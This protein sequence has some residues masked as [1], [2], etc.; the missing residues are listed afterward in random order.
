MVRLFAMTCGWIEADYHGFLEHEPGRLRVPVPCYLIDHPK[1]KVVFDT[2]LHVA[3]QSDPAARLGILARFFS[4][5][6]HAGEDIAARLAALDVDAAT[7]RHL[8]TSH[9]HFDHAGGN[10]ALPNARIVIQRREWEAG[11]DA[12]RIAASAYNPADYDTGQDI[13]P[14]DGEHDLLGDGSV[15]CIP[16]YGHTPGH[17][18]LRV[19][20]A[21]GEV[22]LSS[23]ACGHCATRAPVSSTATTRSSGRPCRRHRRKCARHRSHDARGSLWLSTHRG[24]KRRGRRAPRHHQR[25]RPGT[26]PQVLRLADAA[27]RLPGRHRG[28]RGRRLVR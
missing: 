7:I 13:F 6:F 14:I 1:G 21:D 19:R 22:V 8:V 17:Q 28:R 12:D 25:E 9:L 11:R 27:A 26:F 15:T 23:D 4:V 10:A 20:L 18:S 24:R 3:I 2:G 5:T 16:T